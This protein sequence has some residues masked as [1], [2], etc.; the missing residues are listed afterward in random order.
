[1]GGLLSAI[2]LAILVALG[3]VAVAGARSGRGDS[4]AGQRSVAHRVFRNSAFPMAASLLNK[5][6]DLG[7]AI[8]MFR[9]LGAEGVGAYTFAGVLVTYFDIVVGWGLATLIT[10]DVARDHAQAGPL[11]GERQALRVLLWLGAVGVTALLHGPLAETLGISPLVL[12]GDT[13]CW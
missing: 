5:A 1:M 12:L 3:G 9:L 13:G 7:F 10:R 8:I 2:S 6:V 4:T 11:P